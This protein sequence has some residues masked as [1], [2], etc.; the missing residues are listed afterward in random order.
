L[1]AFLK[2]A[3]ARRLEII[4]LVENLLVDPAAASELPLS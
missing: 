3:P 4:E 1:K 2:L